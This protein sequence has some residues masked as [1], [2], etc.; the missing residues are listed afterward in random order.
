M[1]LIAEKRRTG[2]AMLGIFHD[3]AVRDA[4]ADRVVDVAVSSPA[5]ARE[6]ER[7]DA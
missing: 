5:A 4:V 2:T 6:L 3:A 7:A 1:E